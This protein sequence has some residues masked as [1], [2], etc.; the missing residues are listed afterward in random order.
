VAD[1]IAKVRSIRTTDALWADLGERAKVAGKPRGTY[2]VDQ[3]ERPSF[4]AALETAE[5]VLDEDGRAAVLEL[6]GEGPLAGWTASRMRALAAG[7]NALA[8]RWPR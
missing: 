3:L 4:S 1:D 6:A 5:T 2:V 8:S 7:L